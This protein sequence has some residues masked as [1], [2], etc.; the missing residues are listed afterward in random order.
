MSAFRPIFKTIFQYS[1]DDDALD[2]FFKSVWNNYQFSQKRERCDV[3]NRQS[4]K[5]QERAWK[6]KTC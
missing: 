3:Y 4:D 2:L 1:V 5:S 6:E